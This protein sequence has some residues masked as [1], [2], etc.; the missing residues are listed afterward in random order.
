MFSNFRCK[1]KNQFCGIKYLISAITFGWLLFCFVLPIADIAEHTVVIQWIIF[2]CNYYLITADV[3]S[4]LTFF[5][6][7]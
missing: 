4:F 7:I 5:E 2:F 3:I 1:K 6:V